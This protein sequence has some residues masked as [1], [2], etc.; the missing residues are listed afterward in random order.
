[1][2]NDIYEGNKAVYPQAKAQEI[3]HNQEI[4]AKYGLATMGMMGDMQQ[5]QAILVNQTNPN[6]VVDEII[7]TLQGKVKRED[8]SVITKHEALMNEEG[9]RKAELVLRTTVNQGTTLSHL[10]KEDIAVIMLS[11]ANSYADALALN[12]KEYGIKEKSD[13]DLIFN[14]VTLPCFLAL[15]RAEGQNEKNWLGRIS[16]ENI[17]NAPHIQAPKKDSIWSKIKL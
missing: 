7:L 8:G 2:A 15:K 16:V 13:L 5:N 1:M 4:A 9:I 17:N 6:K 11:F 14:M 10:E 12:W 3:L